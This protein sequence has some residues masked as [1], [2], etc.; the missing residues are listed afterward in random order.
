MKGDIRDDNA[1]YVLYGAKVGLLREVDANTDL[2][3]SLK[4]NHVKFGVEEDESGAHTRGNIEH[5]SMGLY[6]YKF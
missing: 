1:N 4:I 6:S 2:E 5:S 3:L